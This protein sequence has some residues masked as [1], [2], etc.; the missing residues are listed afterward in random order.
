MQAGP[1]IRRLA[2]MEEIAALTPE[3][4][5][6][7][8]YERLER[9]GS[10]QWPVPAAD[11]P[12]TGY[13]HKDKFSRGLGHFSPSPTRIRPRC[14][15]RSIRW[16]DDG[17]DDVP[18]S[19]RQH[20][21][22]LGKAGSGGAR[23]AMWRSAP[24]MPRSLGLGKSETV[25]V[26]SRRGEI[27][28]RAWI[29]R[30][31]P[32][33][34]VFI[35]FHFAEAAANVL[36]NPALDPVAKI[37]EYKVAAVR[38]EKAPPGVDRHGS[39]M[40]DDTLTDNRILVVDDEL[41][42]REGCRRALRRFGYEVDVAATGAEGLRLAG[43]RLLPGADRRDD[44]RYQRHRAPA[45][46]PHARSGDHLHHHHRLCHGGVGRCRHEAW[47]PTTFSPSP[48]RMTTWCGRGEGPGE[49]TAGGRVTA[50]AAGLEEEAQRLSQE[51]AMLEELDRVKSAFMRQV[52]HELRAPIAAIESFMNA[53]VDGYGSPEAQR[54]MQK[55]AAQ[56]AS[57]LLDVGRRSPEPLA[58][59]AGETGIQKREVSVN[60][61]LDEVLAL[62]GCR[63]HPE[64][65]RAAGRAQDCPPLQA[66]PTPHQT[67]VD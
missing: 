49:A 23:R 36:T 18:L 22:S 55:R 67:A 6:G 25:R 39:M 19:H 12:G 24:R 4:Y 52:A 5:G 63:G 34:V 45:H 54:D 44:A 46:H 47:A 14:P 7:V 1:T 61:V 17:P 51:M 26:I 42:L 16:S 65:D 30:R 53:I 43:G 66:D 3:S 33:G 59:Q 64:K 38:I 35:P 11:H 20:D 57:E 58:A 15:T 40:T 31:V 56:R 62:H 28:T 9:E 13:L 48:S 32:P 60:Q 27:E 29:T 2:V 50:P 21:P 37:P 10:L 41:G 8:S